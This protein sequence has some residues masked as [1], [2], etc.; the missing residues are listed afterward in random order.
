M[1]KPY[2]YYE[3]PLLSSFSELLSLNYKKNPDKI[4]FTYKIDKEVINKSYKDFYKDV[5]NLA[6]YLTNKYNNEHIAIISENAYNY[7]VLFFS[8]IISNNI[9]VLIDKDL[10]EESIKKLLK[11]SDTKVLYYSKNHCDLERIIKKYKSYEIDNVLDIPKLNKKETKK[12]C[13][14]S[15]LFFTSGTTGANKCVMLSEENILSDIY[16]AC[17]IFKP[18]GDVFACLPFH[19]AFGLITSIL[20]PFFYNETIFINNSLKTILTDL[21]IS[22]PNTMFVVPTFIETFYKQIWKN[23]KRI[24]R[25]IF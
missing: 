10:D 18:N 21:K 1:N 2:D 7:I 11:Q 12:K 20:K 13:K 8:I 6:N 3:H 17:S 24:K 19:H 22:K 15:V 9:A 5:T 14:E 16:G 23:A 25:H 4:A